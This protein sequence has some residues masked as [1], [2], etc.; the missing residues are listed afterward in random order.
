[1]IRLPPRSTLTDPLVPYTTRFRSDMPLQ[2]QGEAP[3][4]LL[5]RRA[6]GDG[7]RHVGGAVAILP[8]RI[9]QIEAARLYGPVGPFLDPVMHHRA[10][11]P[12][13]GNGVEGQIGRAHV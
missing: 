6:D 7:A 12:R 5:A 4:H 13:A 11:R 9:D 3:L 8:A 2:H 1:M 10:V